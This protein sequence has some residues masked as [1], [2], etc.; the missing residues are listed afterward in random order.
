LLL[1]VVD[2]IMLVKRACER[3]GDIV[4]AFWSNIVWF[5]DRQHRF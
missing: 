2:D 3:A 5:L 4:S 1:V